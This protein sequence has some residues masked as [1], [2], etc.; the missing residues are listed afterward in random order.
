MATSPYLLHVNS[1]PTVV[2][3]PL[4]KEWYIKE[5]LPD[6]VGAKSCDRATFYEEIPHPLNENP[7]H[8]RKF[9]ALY[10]TGFEELLKSDEYKGIRKTSEL[11]DKESSHSK[12]IGDNGDFDARSGR[13]IVLQYGENA[14]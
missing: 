11:F 6:L 5:H 3:N 1:R 9:L 13:L 7:D 12:N 2:S 4:W 14:D 8:P 10:Q